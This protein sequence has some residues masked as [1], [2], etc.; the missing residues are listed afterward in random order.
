MSDLPGF[1]PSAR[2]S[3]TG[4]GLT[5][6]VTGPPLPLL[7]RWWADA[8]ADERVV[9][10]D[11]MVVATVDA[12]GH[13]DARTVLLK[14]LGPAGLTFFTNTGS[15]KGRQL[16]GTPYAALVLLWHAMHR[17]V[18]ARGRVTPVSQ[19]EAA[20]YFTTRPRGS[21]VASAASQQSRPIGSRAELERAVAAEEAR[22]P[23]TGSPADVQLP[24]SWGGYRMRPDAVELWVGQ[25][26]RLHDRIL[27]SRSGSGD[28]DDPES[29]S[30][31][32]LQP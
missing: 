1:E 7:R 4:D 8:V 22:W 16:A 13:P 25:P 6:D 2:R 20:Q 5:D 23:D 31:T 15:A 28:L 10:P 19:E 18:R 24:A 11:A 27:F 26:S 32:R 9:E 21:Q 29:W 14:D 3:Y 30:V 12:D 17:Q